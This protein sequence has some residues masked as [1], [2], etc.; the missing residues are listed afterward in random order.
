MFLYSTSSPLSQYLC[1]CF[2]SNGF[3]TGSCDR[4]YYFSILLQKLLLSVP[5][6]HRKNLLSISC[7]GYRFLLIT[8]FPWDIWYQI[9]RYFFYIKGCLK[10]FFHNR[11]ARRCRTAASGDP[12]QANSLLLTTSTVLQIPFHGPSHRN[13]CYFWSWDAPALLLQLR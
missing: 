5:S 7:K 11:R 8:K 3:R 2:N 1:G 13:S 6:S 10:L 9:K 4:F 12:S